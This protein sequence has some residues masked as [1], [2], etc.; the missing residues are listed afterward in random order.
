MPRTKSG[1]LTG[2]AVT[3]VLISNHNN[4]VEVVNRAQTG[5]I[6]VR[7]DGVDPTVAGDD[8]YVVLGARRIP[9][10]G[11]DITDAEVRLISDANLAYTVE[12]G[13]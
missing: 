7:V 4:A 10:S 1:T 2:G 6:W 3:T 9:V 5:A 12:A 13:G 8:C 11:P